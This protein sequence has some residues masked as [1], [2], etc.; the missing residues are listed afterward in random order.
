[1]GKTEA[2]KW[3]RFI[4]QIIIRDFIRWQMRHP[5]W[6]WVLAGFA[7]VV[8]IFQ[9]LGGADYFRAKIHEW[10]APPTKSVSVR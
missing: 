1:M 7:G 5:V 6:R 9:M 8:L 4:V 10:T 3:I 2:E